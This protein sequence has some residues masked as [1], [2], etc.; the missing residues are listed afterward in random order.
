M[1]LNNVKFNHKRNKVV[2][3]NLNYWSLCLLW[4]KSLNYFLISLLKMYE[5]NK[6]GS[7]LDA[8]TI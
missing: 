8:V 1:S 4:L 2:C 6:K 5:S 7:V 3:K